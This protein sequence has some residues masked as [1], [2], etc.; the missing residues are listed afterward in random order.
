M[1]NTLVLSLALALST[2]ASA[3]NQTFIGPGFAFGLTPPSKWTESRPDFAPVLFSPPG[4]NPDDSPTVIYVRA[5][6]KA[7]LKIRNAAELNALDL[8]EMRVSIPAVQSRKFGSIR[9][10]SGTSA[11]VYEF[12]GGRYHEFVA[13][14]DEGSTM[15]LFVLSSEASPPTASST[16][17]WKALVT[18]YRWLPEL[19]GR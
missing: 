2:S 4:H 12:V 11:D 14:F 19:V 13:Y 7:P 16:S 5:V 18:S 10:A 9:A 1:R 17:A 15:M 8:R 3:Q 6:A